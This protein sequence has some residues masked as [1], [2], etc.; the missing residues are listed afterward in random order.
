MTTKAL[1]LILLGLAVAGLA[2]IV[3]LAG[4]KALESLSPYPPDNNTYYI[5]DY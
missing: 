1:G 3:A 5:G 2:T 4:V